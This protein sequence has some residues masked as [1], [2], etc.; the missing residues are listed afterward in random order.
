MK[1]L[2]QQGLLFIRTP[3]TLLV[4]D[5]AAAHTSF[6][7]GLQKREH[8]LRRKNLCCA[9]DPIQIGELVFLLLINS[10]SFF[11]YPNKPPNQLANT[12]SFSIE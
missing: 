1:P 3:P 5:K 12:F 8:L 10:N 2:Q 6:A 4:G 9:V 7:A 11:K